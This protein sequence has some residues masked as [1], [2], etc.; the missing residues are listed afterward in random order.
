MGG[1][2]SSWLRKTVSNDLS[3]AC[4]SFR[5]LQQPVTMLPKPLPSRSVRLCESVVTY[6]TKDDANLAHPKPQK[7]IYP[8]VLADIPAAFALSWRERGNVSWLHQHLV[9]R[10]SRDAQTVLGRQFTSRF[11]IRRFHPAA[12]VRPFAG[13]NL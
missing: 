7:I 12:V 3:A 9:S 8:V 5:L 11:D 13:S 6:F 2:E 4:F 1:G 10:W